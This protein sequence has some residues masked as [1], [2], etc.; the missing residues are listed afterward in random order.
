MQADVYTH[1]FFFFLLFYCFHCVILL[2]ILFYVCA[3]LSG[4]SNETLWISLSAFEDYNELFSKTGKTR[5]IELS[6]G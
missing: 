2:N 4:R 3:Q 6:A 1:F 5:K